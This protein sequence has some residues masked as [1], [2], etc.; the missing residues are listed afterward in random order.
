MDR[1]ASH[2]GRIVRR[3]RW[4]TSDLHELQVM[5]KASLGDGVQIPHWCAAQPAPL[6]HSGCALQTIGVSAAQIPWAP[7]F[8]IEHRSGTEWCTP[9]GY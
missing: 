6:H 4:I 3:A 5:C 2:R 9:F 1:L 7:S 8:A